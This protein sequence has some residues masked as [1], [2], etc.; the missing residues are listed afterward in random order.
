MVFE[1]FTAVKI[2]I[3]VSCVVTPYSVVVGYRRLRGPC[4]LQHCMALQ[5]RRIRLEHSHI[6]QACAIKMLGNI[7]GPFEKFVDSPYY[8]E[9]E[10][11]GGVVT[12]CFSKYLP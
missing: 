4:C 11:C 9:S 7:R 6:L 3:D 1:R 8:S 10:L 12:V 5:P 2:E